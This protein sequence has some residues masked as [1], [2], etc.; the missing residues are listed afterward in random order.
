MNKRHVRST[1]SYRSAPRHYAQLRSNI[2]RVTIR[3]NDHRSTLL[4]YMLT[5]EA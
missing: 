2:S 3:G 1:R 4:W 5:R